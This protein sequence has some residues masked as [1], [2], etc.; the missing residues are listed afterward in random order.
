[1]RKLL[2]GLVVLSFLASCSSS[3]TTVQENPAIQVAMNLNNVVDDKVK[4]EINPS[5]IKDAS[6]IY[7]IPAI[8]P[9][10]YVISD[11]GKFESF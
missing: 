10:T 11:Y 1:M 7:R 4:V 9:G 6:V 3:K 8:V 2:L 5:K